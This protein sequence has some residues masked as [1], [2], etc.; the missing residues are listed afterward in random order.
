[1]AVSSLLFI[2]LGLGGCAILAVALVL[3]AWA[4]AENRRPPST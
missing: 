3:V 4:L 1:M 2:A